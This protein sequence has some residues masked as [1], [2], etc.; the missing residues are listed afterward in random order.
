MA[1]REPAAEKELTVVPD[2]VD[3][4]PEKALVLDPTI[5]FTKLLAAKVRH[6]YLTDE[7]VFS[8]GEPALAVFYIQSGKVRLTVKSVD[9]EQAV[10]SI[11]PEGS[12]LGEGCLA[13]QKV[14]SAT[15]SALLRSTI[16]R[17]EKQTMTDLL[18]SDAEFSERFL[19]YTL[20]RSIRMAADLADHFFS[21][22]D[23]R[24]ARLQMMTAN[25]SSEWK[26]IP[27]TAKMS[28]ESLA[29]IIGALDSNVSFFLERC[30]ELGFIDSKGVC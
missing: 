4:A 12:F 17:I 3:K 8:Q 20:S 10:I 7:P 29:E 13:G 25:F 11:L 30:C 19:T 6:E 1:P 18:R 23:E 14:R 15:A 24:L 9:G 2:E 16:V 5:W 27:G 22:S 28:P 26:R 21:S